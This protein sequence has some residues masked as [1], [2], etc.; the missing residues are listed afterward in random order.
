VNVIRERSVLLTLTMIL[1]AIVFLVSHATGTVSLYQL[2][3]LD[4]FQT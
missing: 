1:R 3:S 2:F 4:C